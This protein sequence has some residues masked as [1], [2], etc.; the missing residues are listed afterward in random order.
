MAE[1]ESRE[2]TSWWLRVRIP[3]DSRSTREKIELKSVHSL[4][5]PMRFFL[6]K[7]HDGLRNSKKNLRFDPG[8]KGV[9]V[10]LG[11]GKETVIQFFQNPT[12]FEPRPSRLELLKV[13]KVIL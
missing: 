4:V 5:G 8:P 7:I 11:F 13:F 12:G 9:E 10:Q 1:W 2:S 3:F 6:P